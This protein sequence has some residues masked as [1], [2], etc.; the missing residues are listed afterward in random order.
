MASAVNVLLVETDEFELHER[1][2]QLSMDGH[3]VDAVDGVDDARGKACRPAGCVDS[4]RRAADD[5][6]PRDLRGGKIPGADSRAPVLVPGAD[7]DSAA[8]RY[9]RAGADVA[10]PSKSSP[11]VVA[12]G[13]EA[14]MRR[15]GQTPERRQGPGPNLP[16]PPQTT[17]CGPT[18][19][20]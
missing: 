12:A 7:D 13:L 19:G 6:A 3:A 14:L 8:V 5:W 4:G 16:M 10:L 18:V 9:Y 17:Q 11:L 15:G 20:R 2:E 1:A